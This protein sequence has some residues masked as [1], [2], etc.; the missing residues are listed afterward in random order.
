MYKMCDFFCGCGGMGLAFQNAGFEIVGAWDIDKYAVQT[1]KHNV[2]DGVQLA[3][4]RDLHG[5]DIP[6]ADVWSFGFPCQDLSIAGKKKGMVLKCENC[7]RDI[8]ITADSYK[9]D[10]TCPV[11]GSSK[12]K[13]SSRSGCFFEIMRLLEEVETKP[14][15]I[16]AE[17]VKGLKPYLPVLEIE[18]RWHGYTP[19]IQLFNSKYWEVPQNR[20]RYAVVGTAD[21]INFQFPMEQREYV[22]RLADFLDDEVGEKFYISDD[23]ARTIIDQAVQKLGYGCDESA[24][25]AETGMLDPNGCGKTLRIGGGGSLTKKHN[26]QH[27]IRIGNTHPSQRGMNG[28][29]YSDMAVSPTLTTNKGEGIKVVSQHSPTE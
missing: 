4:V 17:N 23:R 2:W 27:V 1:Y 15:V 10:M 28:N 11:C 25:A 22:P 16:I 6:Q 24:I 18:Y 13:A 9:T 21:G 12:F 20:E 14:S 26:Y 29:V 7:G 8:E 3:D 5:S 19:H